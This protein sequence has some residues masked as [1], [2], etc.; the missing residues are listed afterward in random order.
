MAAIAA[1]RPTI[2]SP[3]DQT[4]PDMRV[5][6][7]DENR[8]LDHHLE[9]CQPGGDRCVG[10]IAEF[11]LAGDRRDEVFAVERLQDGL[12][13]RRDGCGAWH[14]AQQR[15][16]ADVVAGSEVCDWKV[17]MSQTSDPAYVGDHAPAT[18]RARRRSRATRSVPSCRR[19]TANTSSPAV[20]RQANSAMPPK[21][22]RHP[23]AV[24]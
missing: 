3:S 19:S 24:L 2:G 9:H 11:A 7:L 1:L 10:R 22:D 14:V 12:T 8:R 23:F 20:T 18:C 6:E 5:G 16:L 21:R 17:A 4:A 13:G 15:D